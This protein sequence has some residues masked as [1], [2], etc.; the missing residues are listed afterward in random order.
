MNRFIRYFNQN[1][2]GI[3]I[4]VAII[5]FVII[6]L[7]IINSLLAVNNENISRNDV[8]DK[9]IKSAITGEK[10]SEKITDENTKTIQDF[11]ENC[12]N[13][14]YEEA[15]N[16]LTEDCKEEYKNDV[17]IF[18]QNYL[19]KIFKTVKTYEIDL[20]LVKENEYTYQVTLY[21]DNL[22]ATGGNDISTN[23]QDHITIINENGEIK[24][25]INNFIRKE[26][27]NKSESINNIEI[28][29][30]NK[31]IYEDY[32]VYNIT[33]KNK[34][35][36]TIMIADRKNLD[37]IC[38]IDERNVEYTS[39]LN[40]L[41][42]TDLIIK[43]SEEKNLNIKFNKLYNTYSRQTKKFKIK[44]I[45]MDYENY[46]Q[47]ANNPSIDKKTIEINIK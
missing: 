43:N 30:N 5:V 36:K 2:K 4:T 21:D 17:N 38:I 27:I 33:V 19:E 40:E 25:S 20:W 18:K 9:P 26:D 14:Q 13:K 29:L 12:N 46:I 3:I 11:I 34:T 32:E 47:N 44:Q 16:M 8:T 37:G 39:M 28:I 10:V 35:D 23:F 7:R 45:I 22:L 15:F 41:L 6:L 24:V 31:K 42:Q 1:K